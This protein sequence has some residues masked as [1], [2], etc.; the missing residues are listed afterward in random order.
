MN[1]CTQENL[2]GYYRNKNLHLRGSSYADV[3]W[4]VTHSSPTNLRRGG[5]R[6]DPKER[7][8]RRLSGGDSRMKRTGVLVVSLRGVNRGFWSHI[9]CSGRDATNFIG[10]GIF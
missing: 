10:L 7:V 6:D 4:R 1:A 8:H 3:L 9:A 2:A 5:V